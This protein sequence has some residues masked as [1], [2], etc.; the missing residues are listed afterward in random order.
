MK[1][2]KNLKYRKKI[3]DKHNLQ[4]KIKKT[5][6]PGLI[7]SLLLLFIYYIENYSE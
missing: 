5:I 4:K 6:L 7:I 1:D 3:I 2:I